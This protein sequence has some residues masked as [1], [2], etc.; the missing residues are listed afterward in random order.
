LSFD[1]AGTVWRA[2]MSNDKSKMNNGKWK[3]FKTSA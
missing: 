1:I 2:A 3:R